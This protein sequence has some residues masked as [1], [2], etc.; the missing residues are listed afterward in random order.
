MRKT[1]ACSLTESEDTQSP[2]LERLREG[3]TSIFEKPVVAVLCRPRS[4]ETT[5]QKPGFLWPRGRKDAE[6]TEGKMQQLSVRG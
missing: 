5:A 4:I 3:V 1:P 6:N 2:C